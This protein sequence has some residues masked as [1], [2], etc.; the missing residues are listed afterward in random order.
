M[1]RSVE[2]HM[3]NLMCE[4]YNPNIHNKT[5]NKIYNECS[6]LT[7]ENNCK[8]NDK[9]IFLDNKC[10][11]KSDVSNNLKYSIYNIYNL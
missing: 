1:A 3:S 10:T 11:Y 5:D 8:Q 7:E 6:I 4:I 2:H 9:C